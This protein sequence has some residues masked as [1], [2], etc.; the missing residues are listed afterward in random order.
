MLSQKLLLQLNQ[1]GQN[2]QV[3][4][5]IVYNTETDE[6]LIYNRRV[7]TLDCVCPFCLGDTLI[8][9]ENHINITPSMHIPNPFAPSISKS[10]L[11][12]LRD[13]MGKY[14]ELLNLNLVQQIRAICLA[15]NITPEEF[16]KHF[17]DFKALD[18]FH[19]KLSEVERKANAETPEAK[20]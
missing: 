19:G 6:G 11:D 8:R 1:A 4:Q 5:A 18:E 17:T 12:K 2:P 20:T 7:N 16:Y 14:T 3:L 10:E 15:M 9:L 13:D